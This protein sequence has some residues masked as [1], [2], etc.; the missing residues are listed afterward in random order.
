MAVGLVIAADGEV[1]LADGDG[2]VAGPL[3]SQPDAAS[4]SAT[5]AI[6]DRDDR[7]PVHRMLTSVCDLGYS[8]VLPGPGGQDLGDAQASDDAQQ[9]NQ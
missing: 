7:D 6:K 3:V 1:A 8:A 4:A 5:I 2:R 9:P